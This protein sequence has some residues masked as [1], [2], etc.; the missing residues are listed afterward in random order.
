[1][2]TG[3]PGLNGVSIL[4]IDSKLP[5]VTVRRLKTQGWW[6]SNT[7]YITFEDVKVPV[8]HLIGKENGGF[9]PI[10]TNFTHE[11][12]SLAV[13]SNRYARS[14]LED[15]I[16]FGR[17][18]QTFGKRLVDH[19]VIRH[20]LAEMIMRIEGTHAFM[21]QIAYQYSRGKMDQAAGPT[22]LLKVMATKTMEFCA[23]EASQILGGNSYIRGG[24]GSR[25]ERLYREV[26]V[27]AIGGGSEEIML[28]LAMRQ[29]KL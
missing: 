25:V 27:N 8:S 29:A 18:R 5:G 10:M 1:V 12:F 7:A 13:M 19:Q 28:D 23:R 9:L 26:R 4:L 24:H 11:R 15:A 2:R 3:G 14:C 20:K 16:K 22:A 21:E 17:V 6:I